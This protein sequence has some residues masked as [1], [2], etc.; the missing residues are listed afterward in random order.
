MIKDSSTTV[1]GDVYDRWTVI[2]PAGR[3]GTG[4]LKW[5]CRCVCGTEKA[6]AG[7]YLRCGVSRS[8]GCLQRERAPGAP[9]TH[10]M[11]TTAEYRAWQAMKQRCLN[12]NNPSFR[13][14]G[15]RGISICEAW[16][17]SFEAFIDDVGRRPSRKHSLHRIDNDGNYEPGN[18]EWA[19][20][21]EQA[22]NRRRPQRKTNKAPKETQFLWRGKW[23]SW[24][25]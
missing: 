6:I 21:K 24:N 2:A 18:V 11:S 10:E 8:C 15:A 25:P 7:T 22:A 1:V 5:L 19:T 20:R 23:R 3:D 9:S 4:H 14:Y 12:A 16:L 13:D 17:E